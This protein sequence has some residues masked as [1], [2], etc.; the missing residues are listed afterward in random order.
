MLIGVADTANNRRVKK[1]HQKRRQLKQCLV[2]GA[3]CGPVFKSDLCRPHYDAQIAGQK[4]RRKESRERL[5]RQA[6]ERRRLLAP[7]RPD[8]R[9]IIGAEQKVKT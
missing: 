4:R 9:S 2:A 5:A 1:L 7:L 8:T 3:K 6:E